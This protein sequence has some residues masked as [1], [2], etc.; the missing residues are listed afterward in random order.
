V[1]NLV[2]HQAAE[3]H[4]QSVDEALLSS[5]CIGK[6]YKV[7]SSEDSRQQYIL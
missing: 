4:Q 1:D 6:K 7:N 5:T 2:N 3:G